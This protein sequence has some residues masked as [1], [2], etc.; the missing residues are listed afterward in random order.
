[1][2]VVQLTD[3]LAR[4]SE[5]YAEESAAMQCSAAQSAVRI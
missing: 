5:A 4:G 2:D 1:M 3:S